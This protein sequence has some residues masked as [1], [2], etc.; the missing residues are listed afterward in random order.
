MIDDNSG[1]ALSAAFGKAMDEADK[2]GRDIALKA[3]NRIT[4]LD[5]G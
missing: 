3:D 5:A 2:T 1:S 4:W